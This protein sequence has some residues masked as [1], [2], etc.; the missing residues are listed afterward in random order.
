MNE[1]V[2]K[3]LISNKRN[4][5]I[6]V[7]D[8]LRYFL[9]DNSIYKMC[10]LSTTVFDKNS[11]YCC[12]IAGI[13]IYNADHIEDDYVK[14]SDHNLPSG[15]NASHWSDPIPLKYVDQWDRVLKLKTFW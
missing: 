15:R 1:V 13:R 6:S 12:S 7:M 2:K 5:C 9:N 10:D 8:F 3:I 14:F 4:I 11:W